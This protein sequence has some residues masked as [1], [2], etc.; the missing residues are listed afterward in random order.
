M[1][2]VPSKNIN[3]VNKDSIMLSYAIQVGYSVD[4]YRK[5]KEKIFQVLNQCFNT[6]TTSRALSLFVLVQSRLQRTFELLLLPPEAGREPT[7]SF[8]FLLKRAENPDLLANDPPTKN[9]D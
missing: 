4:E 8:R 7:N 3:K 6:Q 2:F 1:H 9:I 5:Q